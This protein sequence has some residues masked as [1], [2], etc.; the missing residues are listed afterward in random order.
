MEKNERT[1]T[2]MDEDGESQW[3]N[4]ERKFGSVQQEKMLSVHLRAAWLEGS[5][6]VI[7]IE[8]EQFCVLSGMELCEARVGRDSY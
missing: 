3:R 2:K 7:M 6:L 4:L 1:E 5:L 8:R